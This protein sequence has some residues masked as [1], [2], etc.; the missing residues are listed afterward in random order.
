MVVT[1]LMLSICHGRFRV[2]ASGG[3]S[4]GCGLPI[5]DGAAM[6]GRL[7]QLAAGQAALKGEGVWHFGAARWIAGRTLTAR[8]CIGMGLARS[9]KK[10]CK[11]PKDR[12][13][14]WPKPERC[15]D[16]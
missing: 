5:N 9:A 4:H 16:K 11:L 12:L 2:P 14:I 6:I 10:V 15:C 3:A 8:E 7:A 13:L 1:A